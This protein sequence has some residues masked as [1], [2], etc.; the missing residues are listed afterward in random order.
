MTAAGTR[1]PGID[2]PQ[3]RFALYQ[4]IVDHPGQLTSGRAG[5]S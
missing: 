1:A 5:T 4:A 3:C 2:R